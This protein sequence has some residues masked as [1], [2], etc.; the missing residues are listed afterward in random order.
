MK[1]ERYY[2]LLIFLICILSI[3]AVSAADDTTSN[4]INTNIDDTII[5][6]ADDTTSNTINTN[7]D[8]TIIDS[9]DEEIIDESS[10]ETKLIESSENFISLDSKI[11]G[12]QDEIVI[13]E[14]DY[15][16]DDSTDE[17]YKEGIN[18]TRKVTIDGQNHTISGSNQARIFNISSSDVTIMNINF[19]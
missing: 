15:A 19:I 10:E 6:S 2:I 16:Y 5:D 4:T 1:I 3:S 8:D 11:N 7:I 12:N 13:L 14:K 18:I 9:G 17:S